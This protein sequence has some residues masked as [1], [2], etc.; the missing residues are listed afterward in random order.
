MIHNFIDQKLWLLLNLKNKKCSN[1]FIYLFNIFY[2]R[3]IYFQA[4]IRFWCIL[5]GHFD[6]SKTISRIF[7][8]STHNF[9]DIYVFTQHILLSICIYSG[10]PENMRCEYMHT[11][12]HVCLQM[13]RSQSLRSSYAHSF[14]HLRQDRHGDKEQT[15]EKISRPVR[16]LILFLFLLN[17][18]HTY[19][20]IRYPWILRSARVVLRYF[21]LIL[22]PMDY[23]FFTL[24]YRVSWVKNLQRVEAH[25]P[26]VVLWLCWWPDSHL[27]TRS[28]IRSWFPHLLRSLSLFIFLCFLSVWKYRCVESILCVESMEATIDCQYIK[29]ERNFLMTLIVTLKIFVTR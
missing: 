2:Y 4:V 18:T 29:P 23:V 15:R 5:W 8:D 16:A 17:P 13:E 11:Y 28:H 12:I 10:N 24:S 19:I 3:Y 6:I 7:M 25:T 22:S 9:G 26:V 20:H 27:H 1:T 21:Y 14:P